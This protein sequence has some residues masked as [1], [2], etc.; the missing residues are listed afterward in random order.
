MTLPELMLWRALRGRRLDGLKFRRQHPIGPYILDFFC[1]DRN[2]AIEVDGEG[3]GCD[4]QTRHDRVRDA[5]LAARGIEVLRLPASYVMEEL[6]DAMGMIAAH[7][8]QRKS[9]THTQPRIR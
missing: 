5:W 7:A 8:V 6:T 4:A 9:A 2:L 3:H 1:A